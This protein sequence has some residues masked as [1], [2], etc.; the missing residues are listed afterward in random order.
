MSRTCAV[1][2]EWADGEV[3]RFRLGIRESRDL[4]EKCDAGPAWILTRLNTGSWRLDDIRETLF[5]GLLGGGMEPKKAIRLIEK[6]VDNRPL[7]DNVEIAKA[8]LFARLG[9]VPDDPPKKALGE[10]G[11]ENPSRHSPEEKSDTQKSIIGEEPLDS[12]P[13]T[14][15]NS[16]N[17]SS[18][19]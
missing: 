8:V 6:W 3:Y 11:N 7:W 1:S 15:M 5:Q 17:G 2:L 18:I 19:I 4:Q 13:G 16:L 12:P 10:T 14:L 9:G